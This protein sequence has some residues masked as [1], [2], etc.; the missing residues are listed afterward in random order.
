[1]EKEGSEK[2]LA[3][4]QSPHSSLYGKE[5]KSSDSDGE[6]FQ[7]TKSKSS[8]SS[9]SSPSMPNKNDQASSYS[10][11]NMIHLQNNPLDTDSSLLPPFTSTAFPSIPAKEIESL[12][13]TDCFD[14]I[15][16][17]HSRHS[18]HH[19]HH[20]S[21]N[22]YHGRDSDHSRNDTV[23]PLTELPT[24]AVSVTVHDTC[25]DDNYHDNNGDKDDRKME[26][27]PS[28]S[29]VL[30]DTGIQ[31][32]KIKKDYRNGWILNSI[33]YFIAILITGLNILLVIQV[34]QGES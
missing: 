8:S 5:I 9:T 26:T 33:G 27:N 29:H 24:T 25:D 21:N 31:S 7:D 19:S 11:P 30:N 20:H 3:G 10:K 2:L 15:S 18:H 22:H 4:T 28:S 34:A 1:M 23:S 12:S 16:E 14:T 32:K 13:T 6:E 17:L